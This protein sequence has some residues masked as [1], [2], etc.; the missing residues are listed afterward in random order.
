MALIS[1]YSDGFLL[2]APLCF[3]MRRGKVPYWGL[4]SMLNFAR[5]T[6]NAEELTLKEQASSWGLEINILVSLSL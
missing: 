5:Q 1:I 3:G 4:S 2:R 6:K